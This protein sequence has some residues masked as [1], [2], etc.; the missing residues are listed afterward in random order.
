MANRIKVANANAIET[1]RQRGLCSSPITDA[2][3]AKVK[4]WKAPSL[5]GA[6]TWS[7]STDQIPSAQ[8]LSDVLQVSSQCLRIIQVT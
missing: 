8:S 1:L 7:P 5:A 6:T 4:R 2:P 3:Y